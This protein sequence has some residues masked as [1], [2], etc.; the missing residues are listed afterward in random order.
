MWEPSQRLQ[1]NG[2]I[3]L[4]WEKKDYT[5]L[6]S[7]EF[8]VF[9]LHYLNSMQKFE[10]IKELLRHK[11][12]TTWRIG[13]LYGYTCTAVLTSTSRQNH[14]TALPHIPENIYFQSYRRKIL[15]SDW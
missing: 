9:H 5:R 7:E 6:C 12:F 8:D 2:T 14:L 15:K 11:E 3:L 4:L 1:I 10:Q 13:K